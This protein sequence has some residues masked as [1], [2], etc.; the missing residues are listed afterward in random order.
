MHN[1]WQERS[2]NFLLIYMST[3]FFFYILLVFLSVYSVR[4]GAK[5]LE[6]SR[7]WDLGSEGMWGEK[8]IGHMQ[9]DTY[10]AGPD[11]NG[12]Q[13]VGAERAE[14]LCSSR[15]MGGT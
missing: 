10:D 4:G 12:R 15:S 7:N 6:W 8:G 2:S 5:M 3:L 1:K 14:S 13:C 9:C 11:P